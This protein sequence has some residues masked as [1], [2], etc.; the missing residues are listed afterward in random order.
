MSKN[1]VVIFIS[2]IANSNSW[3]L[4]KKFA[5]KALKTGHNAKCISM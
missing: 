3:A 5:R 4:V 1:I 2:L